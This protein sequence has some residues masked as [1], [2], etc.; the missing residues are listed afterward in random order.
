MKIS[1]FKIAKYSVA[2]GLGAVILMIIDFQFILKSY[3]FFGFL[4]FWGTIILISISIYSFTKK[5]FIINPELTQNQLFYPSLIM[6]L[7]SALIYGVLSWCYITF[8]NPDYQSIIFS[9]AA[10][11]IPNTINS[12][13]TALGNWFTYSAVFQLIYKFIGAA[14]FGLFYIL[15]IVNHFLWIQEFCKNNKST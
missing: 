5:N 9:E 12:A 4:E 8:F 15:F 14:L 10:K 11:Q 6:S 13:G 3:F 7:F 1:L 2:I